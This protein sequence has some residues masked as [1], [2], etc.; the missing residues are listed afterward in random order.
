MAECLLWLIGFNASLKIDQIRRE[1][2]Q[3]VNMAHHPA[4]FIHPGLCLWL[5]CRYGL[6]RLGLV[7]S[8]GLRRRSPVNLINIPSL[9]KSPKTSCP[10]NRISQNQSGRCE[11]LV[12]AQTMKAQLPYFDTIMTLSGQ[13]CASE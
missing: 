13:R 5:G 7:F 1:K 10:K 6:V 11:Q 9:S 4:Q 12:L 2:H 3:D 8:L